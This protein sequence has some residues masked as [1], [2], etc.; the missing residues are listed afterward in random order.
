VAIL[1]DWHEREIEVAKSRRGVLAVVNPFDNLV[2][3]GIMPW[4]PPEL[5]QK[6]YQSRQVRAF[7]GTDLDRAKST[8]GFYS[9]LQ[10]IHS[11]DAITW[12]VFGP[13]IYGDPSHRAM[14][15]SHLLSVLGIP[16]GPQQRTTMWLWR[17]LPHPD[18][19]VSGGPEV[20]FGIQTEHVFVLGEAKWRSAVGRRQG[21]ARDKDQL[22]LRREFC[23]K[24]GR[25]IFPRSQHFIVLALSQNGGV[26]QPA[27]TKTESIQLYTRELTWQT[28]VELPGHPLAE[29]LHSYL[30]WKKRNSKAV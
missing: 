21:K 14:F 7:S 28:M 5:I 9:D 22:T 16:L 4:P 23:E 12:S 18:T 10:S 13:L 11:E 3:T 19:L 25:L 17:R 30:Q 27:Y 2:K 15:T 20:D 26:L 6:L 29:E 1:L 24:Y 8:L